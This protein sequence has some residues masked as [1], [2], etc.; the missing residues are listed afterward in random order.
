MGKIIGLTY[1]L[2]TDWQTKQGDPT[3]IAA[4]LDRPE[5]IERI[6]AAFEKAG[7]TVKRIG[8]VRNLLAQINHLD[9][10]IVFNM[11]EGYNGRISESQVPLLLEMYGIPY[12][13]SDALTMGITLD[14]IVAKKMF[15]SQ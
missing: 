3:D 14:K 4:E 7:H 5:T 8:G 11:C 2:K 9:V 15:I 13:G 10:D 12:V 6:I 1:D